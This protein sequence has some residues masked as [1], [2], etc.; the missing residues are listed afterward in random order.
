MLKICQVDPGC[1]I[2]IPPPNWGAI[3]KI[4]W[5]LY[6]NLKE[7]PE[8]QVDIKMVGSINPGEYDI[9]H[10]HVANL[11]KVLRE[12]NISYI[13]H[14]HDH[15]VVHY[16]KDSGAYKENLEAI[17]NSLITL[18]PAK[19]LVNYLN[20]NKCIYFPH[21]INT[22]EF[23]PLGL[24]KS[25]PSNPKLLM[26]ANNGLA[27]DSTFDRKGFKY[28]V[29]LAMLHNL[30]ITIAGPNNNTHFF[31]ENPWILG[32]NKLNL[33]FDLHNNKLVN[34]YRHHDIFLNPT[35]LEAGHPNLTMLEASSVGL[36]IIG[37]WELE[38]DFHGAYR[39]PRDIFEM[40]RGLTNILENWN[41]YRVNCLKTAKELDW[42]NRTK[43][44]IEIYN[45]RRVN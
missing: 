6:K 42:E 35:M 38:T 13:F 22:K 41:S 33:I 40:S 23:Y 39:A 27:G 16:G 14:L 4:I 17:N 45:E 7:H 28:G 11:T 31:N 24:N 9:V 34:L 8:I 2:P 12:K 21:G 1:G 20:P 29:G 37:D 15:H 26:I 18:V 3:E 5:E 44:L 30:P 10:C 32:Y 25:K 43:H 19:Y 36:P